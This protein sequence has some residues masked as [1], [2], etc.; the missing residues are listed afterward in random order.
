MLKTKLL[1]LLKFYLKMTIK[2]IY[3]VTEKTPLYL[4]YIYMSANA[5]FGPPLDGGTIWRWVCLIMTLYVLL[6]TGLL[7]LA[8]KIEKSRKFL[9]KLLGEE[10]IIKYL[11]K[12]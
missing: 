2:I 8:C 6:N 7:F 9:S 11:G 12:S 3:Y 10:F 4:V 1:S 5:L